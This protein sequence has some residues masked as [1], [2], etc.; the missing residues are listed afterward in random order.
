MSLDRY[1][2]LAQKNGGTQIRLIAG[3]KIVVS[4]AQGDR[5][6]PG[7][8]LTPASL[9]ALIA[10]TMNDAAKAQLKTGKAQW[11][12]TIPPVGAVTFTA[13]SKAGVL[14]VVCALGGLSLIHI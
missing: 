9:E 10:P 3:R 4:T 11:L 1:L 14:T 2:A 6:A 8:D 5:E 13:E 12:G 7:S